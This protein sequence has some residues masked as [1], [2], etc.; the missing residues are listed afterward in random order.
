LF[1]AFVF[2]FMVVRA[3]LETLQTTATDI[4][5]QPQAP[6]SGAC[7]K[8]ETPLLGDKPLPLSS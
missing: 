4:L 6:Q 8:P 2:A 3:F 1:L 5:Y 7:L